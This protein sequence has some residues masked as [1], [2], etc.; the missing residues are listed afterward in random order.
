MMKTSANTLRA[1]LLF[2]LVLMACHTL[3]GRA[4]HAGESNV[5]T[6]AEIK[7]A[8]AQRPLDNVWELISFLRPKFLSPRAQPSVNQGVV[9]VD[10]V[11]YLNNTRYGELAELQNIGA[12]QVVRIEYLKSS[13]ATYRLGIGHE[14]GAILISTR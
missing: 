4:P 14:G 13:E 12:G 6:E 2:C 11:V 8:L 1:V 10:P 3:K 7:A 9:Q 5:I